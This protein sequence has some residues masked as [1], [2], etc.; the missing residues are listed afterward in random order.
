MVAD[1]LC[2]AGSASPEKVTR[3]RIFPVYDA[4]PG[5][6]GSFHLDAKVQ[7]VDDSYELRPSFFPLVSV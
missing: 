5:L 6:V 4:A 3:R 2:D 7:D 1:L